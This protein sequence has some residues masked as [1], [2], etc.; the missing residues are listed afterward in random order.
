MTNQFQTMKELIGK[1]IV[2]IYVNDDQSELVFETNEG[3]IRYVTDADCC[4]ETW[5]AD[6]IGVEAIINQEILSVEDLE[7]PESLQDDSRSRQ[8]SDS[9]YGV[10]LTT[11]KGYCDIVYRNSSNGYYSGD[12]GYYKEPIDISSWKQ[13]TEDWSA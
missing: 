10:K 11:I 2:S 4:S 7:I 8:D 6:L 13:I 9:Y 12:A 1:T 3:Q 5:F